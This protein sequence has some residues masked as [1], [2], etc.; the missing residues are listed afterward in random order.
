MDN[1]DP[2]R[3]EYPGMVLF[4]GG[5]IED[6]KRVAKELYGSEQAVDPMGK[7]TPYHPSKGKFAIAI[8][9]RGI[10]KD[11]LPV[12]DWVFPIVLSPHPEKKFM[13]DTTIESK[14]FS[15]VTGLKWGE[16]ELDH[17]AERCWN[18]HRA[19]TIRDWKTAN[20]REGHDVLPQVYFA[21]E[22]DRAAVSPI[23]TGGAGGL[24][25]KD[26]EEAKTD[27]YRQR[28]WDEKTGAPTRAKLEE[29]DLK[30]VADKLSAA[31]LL[32]G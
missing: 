14:L 4:S 29:L 13:G 3:H 24:D 2:N 18:L 10:L 17:A 21:G 31:K 22:T 5:K 23:P 20:L 8:D 7:I 12:C 1:R 11:S 19:I 6:I 32:P 28:G 9:H 27:Y 16:K 15:A 26:F 30:D 25:R